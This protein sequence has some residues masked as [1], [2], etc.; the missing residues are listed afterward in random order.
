MCLRLGMALVFF[1]GSYVES[2][3]QYGTRRK[4]GHGALVY[5]G[6]KL[7]IFLVLDASFSCPL[8]DS[9]LE[10]CTYIFLQLWIQKSRASPN[11]ITVA[12]AARSQQHCIEG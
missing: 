3:E 12:M 6:H 5:A 8:P 10:H 1:S 4:G 11:R 7:C 2:C 9:G